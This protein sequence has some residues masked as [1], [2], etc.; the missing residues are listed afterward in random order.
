LNIQGKP[1]AMRLAEGLSSCTVTVGDVIIGE[2]YR[3]RRIGA[4]FARGVIQRTVDARDYLY[5][6]GYV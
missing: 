2:E 6:K 1:S 4:S 5:N 3:V